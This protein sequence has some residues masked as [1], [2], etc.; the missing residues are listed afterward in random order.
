MSPL[1]VGTRWVA[2]ALNTRL[3]HAWELRIFW[4]GKSARGWAAKWSAA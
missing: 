1:E 2:L 4:G 3:G